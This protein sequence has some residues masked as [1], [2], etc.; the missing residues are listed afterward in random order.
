MAKVIDG[1]LLKVSKPHGC[2]A[3]AWGSVDL[4]S[5]DGVGVAVGLGPFAG[6]ASEPFVVADG[7]VSPLL[8]EPPL[9]LTNGASLVGRGL[10]AGSGI[11]F[12]TLSSNL[13]SSR[14]W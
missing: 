3:G 12:T 8:V 13:A 14:H 1:I 10:G 9:V 6:V 5:L 2:L 7:G 11:S 4:P